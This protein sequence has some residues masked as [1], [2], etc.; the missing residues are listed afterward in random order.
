MPDLPVLYSFRRC[1]YA[2]RARLAVLASHVT[3]EL[4][5]I[6]LKNKAPEFLAVSPSGTVPMLLLADGTVIDESLD[7][8][9]WVLAQHDPEH[10]LS[11]DDGGFIARNDGPFKRSLDRY[12]YPSRFA[13]ADAHAERSK[14]LAI[15][16]D[17]E[18]RLAW[19][20]YLFGASPSLADMAILPFVR[21]FASVDPQWWS[22]LDRPHV[23]GW[24]GAFLSSGRFE[25]AM[26][27]YPKWQAG[28]P[29][30][31]FGH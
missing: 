28:D 4:R 8:M 22:E 17:Y 20:R 13:G 21:Q 27:K 5:E 25:A 15:L 3:C 26:G 24:L 7:I 2:M 1:P 6:E 14:G 10:W 29:P 16:D 12:K 30:V 19:S 11:V 9:R 18:Q 31:L 23:K